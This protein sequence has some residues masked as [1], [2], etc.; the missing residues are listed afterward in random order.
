MPLRCEPTCDKVY[1]TNWDQHKLLTLAMN[2]S[3][4]ACFTDPEL[5][6]PSGVHVTPTGQV[7]VCG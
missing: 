7:L 2:V 1:I 6:Y 3:V 4:L 5:E